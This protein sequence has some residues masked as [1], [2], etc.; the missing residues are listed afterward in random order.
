MT[1]YYY[2]AIKQADSNV[3]FSPP[4]N[5]LNEHN[6]IERL[7]EALHLLRCWLSSVLKA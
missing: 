1:V 7:M 3:K 2:A 5:Y 6:F 4:I